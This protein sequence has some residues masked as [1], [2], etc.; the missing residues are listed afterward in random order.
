MVS[1]QEH[2]LPRTKTIKSLFK[3]LYDENCAQHPVNGNWTVQQIEHE[4]PLGDYKWKDILGE[5]FPPG[6]ELVSAI[7]TFFPAEADQNRNDA[8]RLDVVLSFSDGI[9]ARYHPK[10]EL[11]WS[12]DP[13]PTEAMQQRINRAAEQQKNTRYNW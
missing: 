5:K 11:I 7:A 8:P 4:L 1:D 10:A 9:T 6:R 12:T 13:Q 3:Q 2:P